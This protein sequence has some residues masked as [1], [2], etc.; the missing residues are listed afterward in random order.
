MQG[1]DRLGKGCKDGARHSRMAKTLVGELDTELPI[2]QP[3]A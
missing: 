3:R 2:K 1:F